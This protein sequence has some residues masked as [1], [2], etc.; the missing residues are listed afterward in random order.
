MPSQSLGWP[1]TRVRTAER[2]G[3]TNLPNS[4]GGPGVFQGTLR[5]VFPVAASVP[6]A[7]LSFRK[8]PA[9]GTLA[10]TAGRGL[11]RPRGRHT[12]P[13][14]GDLAVLPRRF[15]LTL[16]VPALL[17]LAGVVGYHLLEGCSLFDALYLTVITLTTV[18]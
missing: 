17:L 6:L 4:N 15:L 13:R 18:G 10:A 12:T 16:L 8:K 3:R 14:R 9:S 1:P 2:R 11:R 5:P 7:G